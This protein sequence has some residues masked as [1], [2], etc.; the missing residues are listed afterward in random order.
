MSSE[1]RV[2]LGALAPITSEKQILAGINNIISTLIP[3]VGQ[4]PNKNEKVVQWADLLASGL[5]SGLSID[6]GGNLVPVLPPAAEPDLT[7]PPPISGFQAQP[8]FNYVIFSWEQPRYKNHSHVELWRAAFSKKDDTGTEV[9]TTLSDAVFRIMTTSIVCSDTV[10]PGDKWRYWAR[11]VS[12]TGVAGEWTSVDGLAVEV[13]EDPL[14]LI[15]KISGEIQQGDLFPA[16]G[17]KIEHSYVGV[18]QHTQDLIKQQGELQQ[19]TAE[20]Q[21]HADNL[22]QHGTV[23]AQHTNSISANGAAITQQGVIIADH[24]SLLTQHTTQITQNGNS[25]TEQSR[26]L[27]THDSTLVSHGQTLATQTSAISDLKTITETHEATLLSHSQTLTTQ[28]ASISDLRTITQTHDSLLL[29]HTTQ[30]ST[31]NANISTVSQ[32]VDGQG[33]TLAEHTQTLSSHG[34]AIQQQAQINTEQGALINAA[35]TVRIDSGNAVSGFGLMVDGATGRS[36]FIIRADRF[37]IA[38]PQAYDQNG[39]PVV[40]TNAFPFIVDVT[41]PA[42]PKTLIKNAYI[43]Q[44]FIQTLV[45]GS[46]V[47]DRITGQTL[48]GTHIR[49]G[50]M[51]I[52][53][54]FSVDSAGSATLL[55]AF[56]KG[57]AQSSN[58]GAGVTGWMINNAGNAEFNNAVVRGIVYAS[59]GWFNGTVYAEKMVGGAYTKRN[60][61]GQYHADNMDTNWRTALR[62]T[63]ARAMAVSRK[64]EIYGTAGHFSI[65]ASV[66]GSGSGTLSRTTTGTY[67]VR[68][69]RDGVVVEAQQ[70]KGYSVTATSNPSSGPQSKT[71]TG[72]LDVS[73]VANVPSDSATHVY[74]LQFRLVY[75]GGDG[76]GTGSAGCNAADGSTAV[77]YIENGDLT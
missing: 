53:S 41:N 75:I 13:P 12:K 24:T 39:K 31:A 57:T 63:V 62:V 16:L 30:I 29:Q 38:A 3:L 19:H 59:G 37:A 65:T 35:W 40:N 67:E 34:T 14:Y 36:D 26:I 73:L 54:N 45:T 23:L 46:L 9:P 1:A 18:N 6:A 61:S 51:A 11:N 33:K 55:N 25:I 17:D 70:Q 42:V 56:F 66:E 10:L 69:V 52:G 58:Y 20:L 50:D 47:A 77:M 28:G 76:G 72:G 64:L 27:A 49:G 8:S 2:K 44:A 15:D 71:L 4:H 5:I 32:I 68:I 48:T 22:V 43:D 74:D 7:T 21:K 60:Y